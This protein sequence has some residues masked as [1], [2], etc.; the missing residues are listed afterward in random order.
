MWI[1]QYSNHVSLCIDICQ[2]LR[3]HF[4]TGSLNPG[5]CNSFDPHIITK[6]ICK[7]CYRHD[8]PFSFW[9]ARVARF[10]LLFPF[11][12]CRLFAKGSIYVN[13]ARNT[14]GYV[15]LGSPKSVALTYR[16][17]SILSSRSLDLSYCWYLL[18]FFLLSDSFQAFWR[19]RRVG[20]ER[21]ER[22]ERAKLT[23]NST[24][25]AYR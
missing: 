25:N 9:A 20:R 19:Q 12:K 16:H 5:N 11:F 13:F 22:K 14:A 6:K 23:N 4:L 10:T 18:L 7:Q 3:A 8:T 21:D 1:L 17:T 15:Y 2:S 24:L